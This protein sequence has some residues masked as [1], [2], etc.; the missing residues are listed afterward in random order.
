MSTRIL[1]FPRGNFF[2]QGSP[3]PSATLGHA[4]EGMLVRV[5]D[6]HAPG[7]AKL[8]RVVRNASGADITVVPGKLVRFSSG[9]TDEYGG[10]VAGYL[11]SSGG[12]CKPLDDAYASGAVW[13]ANDLAYVVERG[14]CELPAAQGTGTG[15]EFD[16]GDEVR[17]NSSGFADATVSTGYVI[18]RA[19]EDFGTGTATAGDESV[20]VQVEEG[21]R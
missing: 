18:G 6:E 11:A 1:P 8:L 3:T 13:K 12:V 20:M 17:G 16:P 4:L 10:Y 15:A 14:R 19:V 21:F 5:N 7:N 9:D 2:T